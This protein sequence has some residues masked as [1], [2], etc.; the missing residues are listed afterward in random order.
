MSDLGSTA[1]SEID[2]SNNQTPPNGWPGG[3]NPS[4]VEPTARAGMGAMRRYYG[5]INPIHTSSGTSTAYALTSIHAETAYYNGQL[6]SFVAHATCGAT[7]T[8]DI[9]GINAYNLRK[10]TAGAWATLAASDIQANQIVTARY[11]SASMTF[12]IQTISFNPGDYV[13]TSGNNTYTGTNTYTASTTFNVPPSVLG[14]V[15]PTVQN[16]TTGSAAT[17]TT[18][19]NVK[20]IKVRMIGGGGGGGGIGSSTGPTGTTGGDSI[21][22]AIHAAGGVGGTGANSTTPGSGGGGGTGGTGSATLRIAGGSG[23]DPPFSATTIGLGGAGGNGVFGGGAGASSGTTNGNGHAGTAN[24][25]GGGSGSFIVQG[26]GPAGGGG[27]GE[28]VELIIANPAATYVYTVG[29]AGAGG[30]GTGGTAV[31][32][33][34]GAAGFITVE[35]HYSY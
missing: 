24:T 21:F 8:L 32:G 28:Y 5:K 11:N 4:D 27:A 34:A 13:Q 25:G 33:G 18:P 2:A 7:P 35:E 20:W 31:I 29:A 16:F 9:D 23:D 12:D 15:T 1:F 17:Y 19:A 26:N 30:I 3:M 10:F 14:V 6:Y 22:N